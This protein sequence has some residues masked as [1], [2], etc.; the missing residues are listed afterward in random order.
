MSLK[1]NRIFGTLVMV[2]VM[3][4]VL[5]GLMTYD[6]AT[7]VA[8]ASG[9]NS[10][11]TIRELE[12]KRDAQKAEEKKLKQ[13]IANS[14]AQA[15]EYGKEIAN[16]EAE[17]QILA[18]RLEII[19]ELGD[20]WR[21]KSDET[22][23]EIAVLEAQKEKDIAA[24]EEMLRYSYTQ[25]ELS[26]LDIIFDSQSIY[27]LL[28][29]ADLISYHQT[30]NKNILDKL[31][32]T[33]TELETNVAEYNESIEAL[34]GYG[35]E[36]QQ[37]QKE[38]EE[39]QKIAAQ[40][41]AEYEKDAAAKQKLLDQKAKELKEMEADLKRRYEESLKNNTGAATYSGGPFKM[42]LA[43]GTYRLSSG[44]EWRNSPISGKKELHNGLDFAAPKGTPIYAAAAGTVIDARYSS[45][46]GNVI[47]ID[48]GGGVV[49][50]YA[51]CSW[52][53]V[54]VGNVVSAGQQ[55]AKVG[56]TGWSTGNHLHFTVYEKGTAVNP[57]GSKY[58][59]F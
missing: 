58:L 14:A 45:S 32:G 9:N 27:D 40:K 28:S 18:N 15:S 36:Q 13:Q 42:P 39:K 43:Q 10:D 17:S 31:T 57:R 22:M 41:K 47:K 59:N 12:K 51:H 7:S 20:E 49:T 37:L 2:L 54:S 4:F 33:L 26:Y 50:L 8:A 38:L 25:G 34:E 19:G 21:K 52:L 1:N 5:V 11:L 6:A 24:F 55:I 16:L 35:S 46:W 44:F 23:G 48:H 30:A 56:S 29:R 53:G 3:S